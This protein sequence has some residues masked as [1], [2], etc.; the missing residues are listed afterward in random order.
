ME[1]FTGI[2]PMLCM[3][4]MYGSI[5]RHFTNV[6]HGLY[7]WKHL[8]TFYQCCAWALCMKAFTDILPMLCMGFMYGSIYRHFTNVVHGLYV[9][10]H[11][12]TLYQCC[13][14]ALSKHTVVLNLQMNTCQYLVKMYHCCF[15]L[16]ERQF[17]AICFSSK[18]VY[19]KCLVWHSR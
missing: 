18:L 13:A 2:L 14:W 7:I 16:F 19:L 3:G 9:W 10:K 11:L 6:V 4:F 15:S 1:A 5:Y 17:P 8:Q 12:Q